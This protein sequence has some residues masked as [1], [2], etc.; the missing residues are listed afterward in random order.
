MFTTSDNKSLRP[1]RDAVTWHAQQVLGPAIDLGFR[2]DAPVALFAEFFFS[3]PK[4]HFGKHGLLRSAPM[5]HVTKPDCS[6]LVR[7]IE[8]AL[9]DAGALRDDNQVVTIAAAKH[10]ADSHPPGARISVS[11]VGGIQTAIT[12]REGA[13]H[14]EEGAA[15]S[16]GPARPSAT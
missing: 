13:T 1:W 10:Y 7:A 14:D 11:L 15:T 9:V 12:P 2:V 3:R 16:Q 4:G 6:K 5:R 8:D